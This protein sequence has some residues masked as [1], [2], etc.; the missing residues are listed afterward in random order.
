VTT[1]EPQ[2]PDVLVFERGCSSAQRLVVLANFHQNSGS[3]G[4]EPWIYLSSG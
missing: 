2:I 3:G 1:P 4:W